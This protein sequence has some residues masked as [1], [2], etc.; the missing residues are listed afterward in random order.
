[1]K[2]GKILTSD[3]DYVDVWKGM[4]ALQASGKVKS[5]GVSNFSILQLKRL[6]SKCKVPPAVNQVE[7]H[8]YMAQRDMIEFCKSKKIA[9]IAFSPFGS[10]GRPSEILNGYSDPHRILEDP[11]VAEIAKKHKRS[12]AQVRCC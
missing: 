8:P 11:V 7:L 1:M 2:D 10:P 3:V 5:I 12:P 9:L 6:L 4:E